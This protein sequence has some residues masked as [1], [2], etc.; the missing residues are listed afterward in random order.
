MAGTRKAISACLVYLM[1][2]WQC[3]PVVYALPHGGT[4]VGGS[5][6][7]MQPDPL[8]TQISQ[9]SGSAIINW[10]GF[11][12]DVNEL[13]RFIQPG[14]DSVALNRVTGADPSVIL[15]QMVANGRVFLVNPNGVVFAPGSSVDVGSL[16]ATTFDISDGD[17]MAGKYNF[18]QSEGKGASYVINRGEIKVADNGFVF[19]VAPGVGNEGLVIANI[20]KV[21]LGSGRNLTINFDGDMLISYAV[22][23][24]VA[25]KIAGPDGAPLASAV[26]NTGRITANGGEVLLTGDAANEI[27]SSVVN[28]EGIIE[29]GSLVSSGGTVKLIGRGDGIVQNKGEI[30]VSATEAGAEAGSVSIAGQY[31]GNFGSIEAKGAAGAYGGTVTL[32]SS[33]QT[34]AS[35]DSVIDVSGGASSDGGNIYLLSEGN[36]TANG[37]LLARGGEAGGDGGFI[38]LSSEGGLSYTG[39]VD[40]SA[41]NGKTGT[42]FI[43]PKNVTIS[44]AGADPIAANDAFAENAALDADIAVANINAAGAHVVIQANTD[45]TVDADISIAAAGVGLTLQGGRSV[46][47]NNN[48]NTNDGDVSITAN[49]QNADPLNR[50]PGPGSI[51]IDSGATIDVGTADVNLT[52]DGTAATAGGIATGIIVTDGGAVTIESAGGDVELNDVSAGNGTVIVTATDGAITSG[53]TGG[54]NIS[55]LVVNLTTDSSVSNDPSPYSL[56]NPVVINGAIGTDVDPIKTNIGVLTA[57]AIN[58]GVYIDETDGLLINSVTVKEMGILPTYNGVDQVKLG[59]SGAD[60]TFDVSITAGGDVVVGTV[61]APDEVTIESGGTIIDNNQ[62]DNNVTAISLTYNAAGDIGQSAD[63]L[64]SQV[65]SLSATTVDGDIYLWQ[66]I[67]GT[68]ESITAGGTGK[69]IVITNGFNNLTVKTITAAG[70]S[71]T[72]ANDAGSVLDGNAGA[73]NITTAD[74][75]ITTKSGVGEAANGIETAVSTITT[76][77]TD[78]A[79]GTHIDEADGLDSVTVETKGGD[80]NITGSDSV[81][82]TSNTLNSAGTAVSFNNKGG[83]IALGT[84]DAGTDD[85][86]LTAIGAITDDVSDSNA[87]II[88]GSVTVRA[89][90]MGS[91][92]NEIDT[93]IDSLNVIVSAGGIFIS[94]ADDL[95]LT[96]EA[97]GTGNDIKVTNAAGDLTV[98]TAKAPDKVILESAGSIIAAN[99]NSLTISGASAELTAGGEIG[100]EATPLITMATTMSAEANDD[101]YI[102]NRGNLEITT[103]SSANGDIGI[104]SSGDLT[105]GTLTADGTVTLVSSG[106]IY[107]GTGGA[108]TNVTAPTLSMTA[109]QIGDG[110]SDPIRTL[111]GSITAEASAGGISIYDLGVGTLSLISIVAKG[112]GADI[113][114]VGDGDISLG[115]VNA[116]GDE[117]TIEAAGQISDGNGDDTNVTAKK[118]NITAPGGVGALETAV[119]EL[120][121]SGGVSGIA[122]TN[123]KP[124]ALTEETLTNSGSYS[125]VSITILNMDSDSVSLPAGTSLV[126]QTSTG[127]IVFVDL[128]DTISVSGGASITITAGAPGS[129]AV[130]IIG[131]LESNGGDISIAADSH[132]TI[133]LL[134]ADTGDVTVAST[135]GIIIDGNGSDINIIGNEVT[136]S[137]KVPTAREEE[138]HTTYSI[139]NAAAAA[140]ERDTKEL[141]LE[142]TDSTAEAYTAIAE[143]TSANLDIATADA[144]DKAATYE[145]EQA[146]ADEAQLAAD[147]LSTIADAAGIAKSIAAHI[148]DA[149]Q[150]IPLTGDGGG[151]TAAGVLSVVEKTATIAAN[152]AQYIAND[153]AN[154]AQDA[155]ADSVAADALQIALEQDL[156]SDEARAANADE[157]ASIALAAYEAAVVKADHTNAVADQAVIAEDTSNVIGSSDQPLGIQA[158]LLNIDADLS[159]VYVESPAD[160]SLGD[161]SVSGSGNDITITS[162]GNITIAGDVEGPDRITVD[163][164]LSIL[165]GGGLITSSELLLLAETGIGNTGPVQTD[166]D[167]A[168]MDGGVGVV[169]FNNDGPLDF[170]TIGT[171]SGITTDGDIEIE[172]PT[173]YIQGDDIIQEGVANILLTGD[174]LMTGN[175]TLTTAA[176]DITITG[177]VDSQGVT[178]YSMNLNAATGGDVTV[179]GTLGGTT[180]LSAL[181]VF[182]NDI[183]LFDIGG[184][185]AGVN[186]AVSITAD[187]SGSI[188]FTGTTY[189]ANQQTYNA[190]SDTNNIILD[191]GGA[192]TFTSTDDAISFT[193]AVDMNSLDMTV[194]TGSGNIIYNN[195]IT[196]PGNLL[197][198]T[199]GSATFNGMI[200]GLTSLMTNTDGTIHINAGT[201][202]TIGDQ[203][204]N[205]AVILDSDTLLESTG[206][207][208]ITF[209]RTLDGGQDLTINTAGVTTFNDGLVGGIEELTSIT[210]DEPGDTVINTAEINT[211]GD[212]TY[213]DP[214]ELTIDTAL[215]ASAAGDITFNNT[216]DGEQD[217]VLNT[218]GVTAFNAVVGGLDDLTSITTNAAGGTTINTT[219]VSTTGSQTY[220]D[221]VTLTSNTTLTSDGAGNITFN[222]ALNGAYT[223]AMNTSGNN[224]FNAIVGGTNALTS[225]ATNTGGG[226]TINTTGITTSGSQT[227]N[228]AVTLTA[229]TTLTSNSAGNITFNNTLN[230]A[231]TLALNTSGNNVFNGVVGGTSGLSSITTNTGGGTTINT[232]GITTS[233]SQ[234]YNDAV[235]LTSNTTLASSA[236]G[237]ITF[238]STL[239]GAKTLALNTSGNNVFNAIVGGTSALSS[240]TTNTGGGTTINT[241]GITT[242]GSQTYNDAVTL[243][244]NT[245]LASSAV[246]NITFN[247]TLN[248]AYTLALNTTGNNVF[249]AAVGGATALTSVTTDTGGS[250]AVNGGSVTTSGAQTYSDAVTL[251]ADTVFTSTADSVTFSSTI[252]GAHDMTVTTPNTATFNGV[253]GGVAPLI[254]MDVTAG[255]D[256]SMQINVTTG[257]SVDT[258]SADGDITLEST[259]GNLPINVLNPGDGDVSLES[260]EMITDANGASM[261]IVTGNLDMTAVSGIAVSDNPLEVTVSNLAA[262]TQTGGIYIANTG[263]LNISS[264]NGVNGVSVTSA[265]ALGDIDIST[266]ED[267]T[268]DGAVA[269]S[270]AGAGEIKLISGNDVNI[271]G[272]VNGGGGDV[273]IEANNDVNQNGDITNKGN[274]DVTVDAGSGNITMAEDARINIKEGNVI[275]TADDNITISEVTTTTG[276]AGGVVVLEAETGTILDG[277]GPATN[278]ISNN[279]IADAPTGDIAG[280][281]INDFLFAFNNEDN[282]PDL[283]IFNNRLMGGEDIDEL[284]QA[285]S[286]MNSQMIYGADLQKWMMSDPMQ[287]PLLRTTSPLPL[288]TGF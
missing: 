249:N 99:Q 89:T 273:V 12:I 131:N 185:L 272:D 175:T 40:A 268:I 129:G 57:T 240:I 85:V 263:S 58:G 35:T 142:L 69:D 62:M 220:N 42:L 267:L 91:D 254:T 48:I 270:N 67:G 238:N 177:T 74:L 60:G 133:G 14:A 19:L 51:T 191:G 204:Y 211:T 256:V 31:A 184:A 283:I 222:G 117:V 29:A 7:I 182:G 23:G 15:G 49:D 6:Q 93:E 255:S 5:A 41:A 97:K 224:V 200:S 152:V 288:F 189:N 188:T 281:N 87:D 242:S 251:G 180:A 207:G 237:N 148:A 68:I 243:T 124:L 36:T 146:D 118:M 66:G 159:S 174:V 90:A 128:N 264:V 72:I 120:S 221:P 277:N 199:T 102:N 286:P 104:T 246:G 241:T 232:T 229:N 114:I 193:G 187:N 54:T 24:T 161:I 210:T 284:Y 155:L 140:S 110:S 2:I 37:A 227:Y 107:D 209:N 280:T 145:S 8:T 56:T 86:S 172:S 136:L 252:N 143:S 28:Q 17:F 156:S 94:E 108:D 203:E 157:N 153:E 115:T 169:K 53:V 10:N 43:D 13:V 1:I 158:N 59:S 206:G 47:V 139:S 235:T 245:T 52:V 25:E 285:L 259:A 262:A 144:E 116:G 205:D 141:I 260:T 16:L 163:S 109:K 215:S 261:N 231:K 113:S 154:E 223:L 202:S 160:I 100:S 50:D 121:A 183:S 126:L 201:I 166:V 276:G 70:G 98:T 236:A 78:A 84:V 44:A 75:T 76:K 186:G 96:A 274:G 212:Q 164:A 134:N 106:I 22:S 151:A 244:S 195:T 230:G 119:D 130:A 32:E 282:L 88:A 167:E 81:V 275:L 105:L 216:L 64:E 279:I 20:G 149:A 3:S 196:G 122:I 228:D 217:I 253:I 168:A 218:A 138:L 127:N 71:V 77:V 194:T 123:S 250:T 213:N 135:N 178:P 132:I 171:T 103:G 258:S 181:T 46:I 33:K 219:A 45:I 208:D 179:M 73:M 95:E 176:G 111:V 173:I 26:S 4:V 225:I 65:E 247:G 38:E 80:V 271:E 11:S 137:G 83:G 34:L 197:V 266:T 198:S 278:V 30:D 18:A 165:D 233:G 9:T 226:T 92:G 21:V 147:I 162:E 125:A 150:A 257:I 239:N 112:S 214:V 79:K 287:I 39:S 82:F 269:V 27:V 192:T 248:G 55:A 265:S 234:T 101:L 170:I 61:V 63:A 190:G